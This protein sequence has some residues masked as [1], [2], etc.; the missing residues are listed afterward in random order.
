MKKIHQVLGVSLITSSVACYRDDRQ[1]V[2]AHTKIHMGV[3]ICQ[4]T[5]RTFFSRT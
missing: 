5:K 2:K 1:R 4:L 3:L